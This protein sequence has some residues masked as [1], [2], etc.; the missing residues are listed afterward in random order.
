MTAIDMDEFSDML[1]Q[2]DEEL[3]RLQDTNCCQSNEIK[4]IAVQVYLV[5]MGEKGE[6][7]CVPT[8]F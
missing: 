3:Y 6:K 2:A 1:G 4:H 7:K 8:E 5:T